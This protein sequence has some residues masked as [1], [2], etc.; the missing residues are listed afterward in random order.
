MT[1]DCKNCRN[2]IENGELFECT[3][4]GAYFCEKCTVKTKNICPY[5]YSSL[6]I[7]G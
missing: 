2:N 6:E 7:K 5:C 1:N 4:C 3:N